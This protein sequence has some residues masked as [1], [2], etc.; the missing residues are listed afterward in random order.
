[1][2]VQIAVRISGCQVFKLSDAGIKSIFNQFATRYLPQNVD[3]K[4]RIPNFK[5]RCSEIWDSIT[6]DI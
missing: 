3:T 5:T 4:R 1:M 2:G 6:I